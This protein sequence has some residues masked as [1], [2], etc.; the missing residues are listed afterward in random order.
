[1]EAAERGGLGA[2]YYRKSSNYLRCN[3]LGLDIDSGLSLDQA[4]EK[5]ADLA[6][7]IYTTPS[8]Q[9]PKRESPPCDR[10]R[11]VLA[12]DEVLTEAQDYEAVVRGAGGRSL[13]QRRRALVCR[14]Y[15]GR[16]N[17]ILSSSRLTTGLMDSVYG[18]LQENAV[19]KP[20]YFAADPER[21]IP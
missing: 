21:I 14:Q 13:V 2:P 15:G 12:L 19:L 18:A 17:R 20:S 5:F 3:V 1:M 16:G 8:H 7:L 11:V 6:L 10:Y 4:R 9:K